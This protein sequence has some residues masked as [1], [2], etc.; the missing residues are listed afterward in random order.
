MGH[1]TS[2]R[3]NLFLATLGLSLLGAVMVY[4]ATYRD[5]GAHYLIVRAAHIVLGVVIFA[6]VRKI[7]YTTWRRVYPAFYLAVLAALLLVLVPGIGTEVGGARRWFDLGFL[8]LQP[9]EF[10]KLAAIFVASFAL[11]R[12]RPGRKFPVGALAAVGLLFLLVVAEPDFGT[13]LV[14]LSGVGGVLLA[15]EVRT[16]SLLSLGAVSTVGLVGVMLLEPYRRQRFLAFLDPWSSARGSGYQIVQSMLAIRSGNL[17]GA[18]PGA[19][20]RVAYIP[21]IRTDM[22]F[23]LIGEELGL[24]GMLVVIGVFVFVALAGYR[25]AL[26]APT[27]AA[28]CVAAG[29]TTML[30]VQAVFNVGAA[31]GV[32]PLAGMTL[33]FVSYGGSS[34]MVSFAAV[35]ILYRISEDS[36]RVREVDAGASASEDTDSGRRDGRAR[37]PRALR[38]RGARRAGGHG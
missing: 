20:E 24:I 7:R 16:R 5:Y 8:S 27:T 13:S 28:R 33:P 30:T 31:T 3:S 17:L 23:A 26:G 11:A 18:G 14:I 37:D 25:I 34:L 32:L 19:G 35:G 1:G 22:V 15:S 2:L 12:Y 10:A 36:E 29:I 9:S 6:V 4:S 21:E 38:G